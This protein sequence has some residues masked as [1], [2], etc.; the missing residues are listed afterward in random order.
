MAAAAAISNHCSGQA[1]VGRGEGASALSF[2]LDVEDFRK[3]LIASMTMPTA[4]MESK[5]G[6]EVNLI[7][8]KPSAFVGV[9][10][11]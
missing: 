4:S 9:A 6:M 5:V 7:K 8:P 10:I 2:G 3:S 11:G 1:S